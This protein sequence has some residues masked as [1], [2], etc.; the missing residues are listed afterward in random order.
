MKNFKE[1]PSRPINNGIQYIFKADNGY[2]ASIVQ[3][4]FSYGGKKGLWELAVIKYD[5]DGEW[6]ICYNTS[7]TSDVLGYLSEDDVTDYLTQIEQL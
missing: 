7:I 1:L 5:E 2:G 6:D 4:D 3:H